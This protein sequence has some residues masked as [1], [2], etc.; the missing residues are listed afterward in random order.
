VRPAN[1]KSHKIKAFPRVGN[2]MVLRALISPRPDA[3]TVINFFSLSYVA[4]NLFPFHTP[5]KKELPFRSA[6]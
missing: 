3:D 5:K 1:A 4:W 2:T 6:V